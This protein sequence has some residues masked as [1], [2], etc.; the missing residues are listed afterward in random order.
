MLERGRKTSV[1][2]FNKMNK[3]TE[4]LC[5]LCSNSKVFVKTEEA[6]EVHAKPTIHCRYIAYWKSMYQPCCCTM[7]ENCDHLS[8]QSCTCPKCCTCIQTIVPC[9]TCKNKDRSYSPCYHMPG[10]CQSYLKTIF[11]QEKSSDT[12]EPMA[13]E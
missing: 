1:T 10:I 4:C 6:K 12:E 7:H 9:D 3:E 2:L 13:V 8:I 11:K 5:M